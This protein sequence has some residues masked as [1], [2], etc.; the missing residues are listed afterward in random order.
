MKKNI[1]L[2]LFFLFSMTFATAMALKGRHHCFGAVFEW[3]RH[4][5][6]TFF[7]THGRDF[8]RVWGGQTGWEIV[9]GDHWIV[10]HLKKDKNGHLPAEW[11]IDETKGKK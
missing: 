5:Y 3:E 10:E 9:N 1:S 7:F 8:A 4:R 2:I 11:F 6:P